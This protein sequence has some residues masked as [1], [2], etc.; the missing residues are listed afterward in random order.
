MLRKDL[1]W[2]T[3]IESFKLSYQVENHHGKL[4]FLSIYKIVESLVIEKER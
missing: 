2:T 3:I 1:L 4:S